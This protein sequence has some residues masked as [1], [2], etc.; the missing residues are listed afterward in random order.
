MKTTELKGRKVIVAGA[1]STGQSVA[2]F[3]DRAG[4]A[5]SMADAR[6]DEPGNMATL[7]LNGETLATADV[8]VLSPGI[9]RAGDAVQAAIDKG[10]RV[11]GDIEL[12]AGE[13]D[14][15]VVAVTGSNG[16]STVAAW[17][18]QMLRALGCN[19]VACGNIGRP[20]LDM[21]E[22]ADADADGS[23]DKAGKRPEVLVLELS[24]YQL[25]STESLRPLAATVLNVSDDHLDR[26]ESIEAY[27]AVKRHIYDGASNCV[28]NLDDARTCA[29]DKSASCAGFT[30]AGG[31]GKAAAPSVTD[32]VR[33]VYALASRVGSG[34]DSGVGSRPDSAGSSV[35]AGV[36]SREEAA[37]SASVRRDWLVVSDEG[38][39]AEFLVAADRLPL[40]GRHNV[41]NALAALALIRPLVDAG[42]VKATLQM[43][44]GAMLAFRGLAH[45][46]EL[47]GEHAGVRWY[48]DSKGT[49]IDACEKAVSAMPGPVILIAGGLGKG[50]DFGAL[51]E[52]L[53]GSLKALL[54][55]GRDREVMANALEG[56]AP[57]H[58]VDSM[59]EAVRLAARMA[60]AGDVVL[61][62]PA[63]A[64]F[65]MFDSFEHRGDVFRSL[66]S[67]VLAA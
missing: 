19:A 16:K 11:I 47:V 25:E 9:P 23:K 45:R 63:C 31:V 64:S 50:A 41:A 2:R 6:F 66:V 18:E 48:N 21:L 22:G 39:D 51:R 3:L 58:R 13:V 52:P 34:L 67:E 4:V 15:P 27:A 24:S 53:A 60:K 61:L 40:P 36:G 12:F 56:L 7:P 65:D 28:I 62:S 42:I 43:A 59:A 37:P 44:A 32:D 5:W 26:Y 30:L 55:M 57:V 29:A 46:T 17:L 10:V 49:N 8:V 38:D 14:V 35:D 54:L 1:G 33:C 20:A